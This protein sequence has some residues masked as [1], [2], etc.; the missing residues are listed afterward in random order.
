MVYEMHLNASRLYSLCPSFMTDRPSFRSAVLSEIPFSCLYA[1][2]NELRDAVLH[3]TICYSL[4]LCIFPAHTPGLGSLICCLPGRTLPPNCICPLCPS[5]RLV[6][7]CP[8][9]YGNMNGL[10]SW[11]QLICIPLF[12]YTR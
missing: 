8:P 11:P 3:L 7:H 12:V 1:A 5:P 10:S 2:S 4:T 6:V 9:N